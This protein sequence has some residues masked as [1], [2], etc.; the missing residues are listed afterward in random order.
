MN[1]T[2]EFI[3]I[4]RILNAIPERVFQAWT[5]PNKLFKWWGPPGSQVK[6]VELNLQVGGHYRIGFEFEEGPRMFVGGTYQEIAPQ[7][8]LVFTWRWENENMDIGESLVTI[9]LE[10]KGDQTA[11]FL[12]HEKL[13]NEEARVSHEEG[14]DG[15]LSE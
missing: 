15:I 4:S 3:S 2:E 5:D 11:L 8:K 9:E 7:Q 6:E 10:E 14:W 1:T 13:P 12:K